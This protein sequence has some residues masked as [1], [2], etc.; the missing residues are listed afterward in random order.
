MSA[1]FDAIDPRTSV[2]AGVGWC[3]IVPLSL[4]WWWQSGQ[5]GFTARLAWGL[6]AIAGTGV[7]AGALAGH[8]WRQL[9]RTLAQRAAHD[10]SP[11]A[12]QRAHEANAVVHALNTTLAHQAEQNARQKRM[13]ADAAH[14]L[15]TP[16]AALRTLLQST[17]PVSLAQHL[18]DML[19]TVDR[20]TNVAN[21][22]L[23]QMK[24]EQRVAAAREGGTLTTL[25]LDDVAREA[26]LEFSPLIANKRLAFELD[27][28]KVPVKADAWMLG[29]LVRN[30]LANAIGQT[31]DGAPLGIVVRHALGAPELVVWDSGSGI[32]DDVRERAFEPFAAATRGTGVGLGLSICRQ[33]AQAMGARVEL[34]NRSDGEQ[35]IGVDAVVRWH[36]PESQPVVEGDKP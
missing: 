22:F 17:P 30:L 8:A 4:L 35:V 15:R 18:P 2:G 6:A 5:Q 11:I 25:Q 28:L 9:Q 13:V 23:S 1:L 24:V 27:A 7:A 10:L 14:Q 31:P 19:R 12:A 29:E 20:A 33:L 3:V 26:A 36:G 16:L 32:A 34:F 21:E